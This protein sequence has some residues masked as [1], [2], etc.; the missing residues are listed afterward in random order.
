MVASPEEDMEEP[1]PADEQ[2][3]EDRDDDDGSLTE[4]YEADE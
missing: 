4:E 2:L 3:D 1:L